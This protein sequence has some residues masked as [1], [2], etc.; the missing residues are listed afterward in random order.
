[1]IQPLEQEQSVISV[2]EKY[3]IKN[4]LV[5]KKFSRKLIPSSNSMFDPIKKPCI[6][7]KE[8][9]HDIGKKINKYKQS[10]T[11]EIV[12]RRENDPTTPIHLFL[13]RGA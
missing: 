13:T 10:I 4:D 8:D 6:M 11:K 1:M 3:D 2:F 5:Q 9:Y 12:M 7:R